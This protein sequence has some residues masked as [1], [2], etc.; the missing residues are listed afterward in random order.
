MMLASYGGII[1]P[2]PGVPAAWS[3]AAFDHFRA[4]GAFFVSAQRRAGFTKFVRVESLAGEPC[5]VRHGLSGT[6]KAS[7]ERAFSLTD[8]G[9]GVVQVD[10][11]QGEHVILYSDAT[12]PDLTIRPVT[13]PDRITFWG[14]NSTPAPIVGLLSQ[15]KPST[16]STTDSSGNTP[17][18]ASDGD[19]A[20]R[21][22][23]S[24]SAYPQWWRVDLGAAK[25][26]ERV[27][28]AWYSSSSRAYRY[29]IET[30]SDGSAFATAVDRTSN[31]NVGDTSDDLTATA[32][33]LRVYLTGSSAGSASAYEIKVFGR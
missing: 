12:V 15:G 4:E 17:A 27:D 33:Y 18:R 9:G 29:R 16:A 23:A 21:W 3:D 20:T 6:V 24:S 5:K 32:R 1:R 22:S 10:L 8:L 7:G 26:I 13:V 28:V 25:A 30:S 2:F 19:G 31:G 11:Q 14:V